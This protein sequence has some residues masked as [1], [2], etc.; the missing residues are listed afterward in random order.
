MKINI[1]SY[2]NTIL[3][4]L[5]E[6]GYEAYIVGGCVRDA[7]L[8]IPPSDYDVC[9]NCLPNKMEEIFI[10]FNT[11]ETGIKHGTLTV[12]SEGNPIEITT[13]RTDGEYIGHRKP[14]NVTFEASLSEDLK[15]RDFTIN[16]LCCDKKGNLTDLFGGCEDIENCIIKCVGKPS[17]RFDEDALRI[18]RAV[19]F[20][21]VLRFK[22]DRETEIAIQNQ[23]E[24]LMEIS[25]ERIFSELKKLICGKSAGQILYNYRDVFGEIIPELKPCFDF[26]QKCPHHCYDVYKHICVSVD[27]IK[28][29]DTLRLVMLLHDIGK[30][31][32]M[33]QDEN[34]IMHFKKHQFAGANKAKT[35]LERLKCD[36]KT[37]ERIFNLI[38]EHDNRI[39]SLKKS[40]RKMI[41]KYG[42]DFFED[43]LCVRRAD[44]LAQSDFHREEK[45]AQLDKLE[46]LAQEIKEENSCLKI[47]DLDVSGHDMINLG[48][49][50]KNIG[51]ALA[52]SLSA[53]LDEKTENKK[54]KIINYLRENFQNE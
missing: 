5:N 51:L 40:V 18:M 15:R 3:D 45:L 25:V 39:P 46:Q 28:S 38:W 47:S 16:A 24:L 30:P 32:M 54:E 37:Q 17:K 33:T 12:M 22:I 14:Q 49:Y 35:I 20:A 34:G 36:K 7:I 44:T 11:I 29:D 27:N 4:R 2:V 9:T 6:N 10:D 19:R 48:Y 31:E 53:V 1:P 26:P 21:S 52:F 41:S 42:F 8:G 50:G 13:F 43:Y 23:K